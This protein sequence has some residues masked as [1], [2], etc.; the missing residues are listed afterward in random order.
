MSVSV[1]P[2]ETAHIWIY[3]VCKSQ[4]L[5]PIAVKELMV[6]LKVSLKR[7][8][9]SFIVRLNKLFCPTVRILFQKYVRYKNLVSILNLGDTACRDLLNVLPL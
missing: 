7:F 1:D 9:F 5:S 8:V 3:A 6:L 4:L 2:D